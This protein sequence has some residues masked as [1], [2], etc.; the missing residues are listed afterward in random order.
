[1]CTWAPKRRGFVNILLCFF[2]SH[3]WRPPHFLLLYRS[4]RSRK[5]KYLLLGASVVFFAAPFGVLV[6]ESKRKEAL[7]CKHA[8]LYRIPRCVGAER[9]GYT[10]AV[11]HFGSCESD[12]GRAGRDGG[13]STQAT[14]PAALKG[15]VRLLHI[16]PILAGVCMHGS[17]RLRS[18]QHVV[19]ISCRVNIALHIKLSSFAFWR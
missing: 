15:N 1:M 12:G 8:V 7:C 3:P 11:H 13:V 4:C 17:Q 9:S 14:V 16:S 10:C 5:C 19:Q 6:V 18:R 2:P